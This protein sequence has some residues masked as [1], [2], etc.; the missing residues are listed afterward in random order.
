MAITWANVPVVKYLW[1]W[2]RVRE[3]RIFEADQHLPPVMRQF[4][5]GE[6][7]PLKGYA[8]RIG[9]IGPHAIVLAPIGFTGKKAKDIAARL[10]RDERVDQ[11]N[12]VR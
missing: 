9:H 7:I 5:V 11:S 8:W 2:W 10:R 4:A 1:A 3:R 6:I 12:A